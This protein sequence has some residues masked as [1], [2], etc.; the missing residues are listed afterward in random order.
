MRF[1]DYPFLRYLLFFLA[2]ICLSFLFPF[3]VSKL[4]FLISIVLLWLI[5][6]LAVR[7]K[8]NLSILTW[9]AYSQLIVLGW[10]L[11]SF[12]RE[13]Q[14]ETVLDG[15]YLAQVQAYDLQKPNSKE[16]LLLA[17]YYFDSSKWIKVNQQIII[18]HQSA[19]EF[20]PGQWVLVSDKPEQIEAPRNPNEFDYKGFLL[21]K[22]IT[23]RQFIPEGKSQI[24]SIETN[25]PFYFF[26]DDLRK[27]LSDLLEKHI[28]QNSSLPIAKALLL[29][30]KNHLDHSTRQAYSESG[31]MHIL[32]VSGLHVG[33]LVAVL[34]FL[35]RPL[36]LSGLARKSYLL[37][38][39]LVIWTYAT[40]TGLSPSVVRA[41]VMFTLIVLGQLRDRKPPIFNI[42]AFSAI[43]MIAVNPGVITEV[44]FQLSYLAVAGIILLQPLIV[45]VW[46]PKS[47][48]LEYLWQL[49]AVSIAAQLATFPLSVWY[50]HSFP[51][52]FLPA[53]LLVIPITFLIMQV[54]IPMLLIG[55]IPFLG[56]ALGWVVGSLIQV[57]LWILEAF[58]LLPFRLNELTIQP[59]TM[60]LVWSLLLV[61]AA[62]EY[63]P[64]KQLAFWSVALLFVWAMSGMLQLISNQ[65]PEVVIYRAEEG[66]AIDYWTGVELKSYNQSISSEDADYVIL[67]NRVKSNWGNDPQE[68][69]VFSTQEGDLYFS[70]LDLT[71]NEK[72]MVLGQKSPQNIQMWDS[73]GWIKHSDSKS[74]EIPFTALRL[75]F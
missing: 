16:N 21:L 50:F 23:A 67:P 48:I 20:I 44:G 24:I 56:K 64:K 60:L 72:R 57:E 22:G 12:H 18:Y 66:W 7:Q 51:V 31:V 19:S 13:E 39:V 45:R 14:K 43:L 75:T 70:E 59:V 3:G 35:I 5:Y 55:W 37:V 6:F 11:P 9:L 32:A 33:I 29:G 25:R 47:R 54:G 52:W 8:A 30:Q 17:Q 26:A 62:W 41:S 65:K 1:S 40:I 69:Q 38:L 27:S 28:P 68:L 42:L 4:V 73:Q 49:G 53:N 10:L 71:I 15:P 63:V 46:Y 58:R 74:L 34:L 36:K 2:G 61:W